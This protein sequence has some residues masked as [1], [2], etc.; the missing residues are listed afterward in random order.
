M[1]GHPTA[2]RRHAMEQ[3]VGFG[4]PRAGIEFIITLIMT[5]LNFEAAQSGRTG[6]HVT[7]NFT[8]LIPGGFPAGGGIH[9]NI[10]R[11]RSPPFTTG[12]D[13]TC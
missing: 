6:E 9:G 13:R 7:L 4:Q 8:G 5:E 10:N 3:L 11:P 12:I 2:D 1:Y